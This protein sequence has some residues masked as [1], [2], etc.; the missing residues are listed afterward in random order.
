MMAVQ[1]ISSVDLLYRFRFPVFQFE[2]L[3]V[4][5]QTIEMQLEKFSDLIRVRPADRQYAY[6]A[7]SP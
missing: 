3:V 1:I 6:S 5:A 2:L 7:R 4:K